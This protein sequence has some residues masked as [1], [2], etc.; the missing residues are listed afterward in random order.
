MFIALFIALPR[1]RCS[2]VRSPD[3]TSTLNWAQT[4]AIIAQPLRVV[5]YILPA[6]CMAVFRFGEGNPSSVCTCEGRRAGRLNK[7]YLRRS[8]CVNYMRN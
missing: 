1:A 6:K 3:K 8:G 7:N 4:N 2:V 5:R